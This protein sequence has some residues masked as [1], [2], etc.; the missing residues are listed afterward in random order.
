MDNINEKILLFI[1]RFRLSR[2]PYTGGIEKEDTFKECSYF[3]NGYITALSDI[4]NMHLGAN[5][6][7]WTGKRLGRDMYLIWTTNLRRCH[8]DKSDEE[9]IEIAV[10][11]LE[12][13]FT[14]NPD[15]Y[16]AERWRV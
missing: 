7:V 1:S 14:E 13:F 4:Y 12:E 3:L 10:N 11:L 8:K 15:W 16:N 5:L 9:L 2:S 6:A